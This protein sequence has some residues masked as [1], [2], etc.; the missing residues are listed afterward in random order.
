MNLS[1]PL[2]SIYFYIFIFLLIIF[3]ILNKMREKENLDIMDILEILELYRIKNFYFEIFQ[4]FIYFLLNFLVFLYLRLIFI[5]N[6]KKSGIEFLNNIF[7]LSNIFDI[8]FIFLSIILY[9]KI[10]EILFYPS[11]IKIHIFLSKFKNYTQFTNFMFENS[12]FISTKFN[13]ICTFFSQLTLDED[14]V[15][16]YIELKLRRK[17]MDYSLKLED[18]PKEIYYNDIDYKIWK[19]VNNN[20]IIYY[21]CRFFC[22]IEKNFNNTSNI[23]KIFYYLPGYF[24]IF[25]LIFDLY[26]NEI[27]YFQFALLFLLITNFI[28]KFRY[29]YE[30]KFYRYDEIISGYLYFEKFIIISEKKIDNKEELKEYLNFDRKDIIKYINNNFTRDIIIE[31][32]NDSYRSNNRS[33]RLLMIFLILISSIFFYLT[34]KYFLL[35]FDKSINFYLYSLFLVILLYLVHRNIKYFSKEIDDFKEN[36]FYKNLF[37]MLV[38]ILGFPIIY[39]ILK[40]KLVMDPTENIFEVKG[41]IKII[42]K[43]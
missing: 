30:S 28:K 41:I 31:L 40:N 27:Y 13:E 33:K 15:K 25:V 39:I 24:C 18:F 2:Q 4:I 32:Q 23:S 11:I 34:N 9:M 3:L 1:N 20:K 19:I 16:R 7:L 10:I 17:H 12:S 43:L 6:E 35:I 42:E 26:N 8:F 29:F 14:F 21:F 37:R 38:L 5:I 36:L 22:I